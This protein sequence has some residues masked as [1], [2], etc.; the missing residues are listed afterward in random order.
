MSNLENQCTAMHPESEAREDHKSSVGCQT[1]VEKP[2]YL[3]YIYDPGVLDPLMNQIKRLGK[4]E[5]VKNKKVWI[6]MLL[7]K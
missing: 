7:L 3:C 6:F 2:S 4:R 5:V 1:P